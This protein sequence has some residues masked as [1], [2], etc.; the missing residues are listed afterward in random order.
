MNLLNL[1]L[2]ILL[3]L[4]Y[5]FHPP[6]YSPYLLYLSYFSHFTSFTLPWT[7]FNLLQYSLALP[8]FHELTLVIYLRILLCLTAP[9]LHLL[10]LYFTQ[11]LHETY[12]KCTNIEP[13]SSTEHQQHTPSPKQQQQQQANK[14][15]NKKTGRQTHQPTHKQT[16]KYGRKNAS[17]RPGIIFGFVRPRLRIWI[18]LRLRLWPG[19]SCACQPQEW[20][21]LSLL[22]LFPEVVDYWSL[23]LIILLIYLRC[24]F[25]LFW[26]LSCYFFKII[27]IWSH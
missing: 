11:T 14:H 9:L 1:T 13:K 7:H 12:G 26:I 20:V 22:S 24:L 10:Y 17:P 16:N 21:S 27:I 19:W 5:L 8:L 6:S 2:I 23:R 15:T 18:P 25:I 4:L 3:I